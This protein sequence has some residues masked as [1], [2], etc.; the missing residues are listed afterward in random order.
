MRTFDLLVALFALVQLAR[1]GRRAL[2]FVA[3]S[4]RHWGDPRAPVSS[5]PRLR[6][7][8]ALEELGFVPLGTRGE[9][10]TLGAFDEALDAYAHAERGAYADVL[11]GP[12]REGP[13]TFLFTPFADGAAVLTATYPRKARSTARALVGSVPGGVGAALATHEVAVRRLAAVH[14]SPQVAPDLGARIEAA[15]AWYRGEGRS[16]LRRASAIAFVNAA[17]GLALLAG[18]AVNLLARGL[19]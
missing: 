1:Y 3:P 5:A 14:G 19:R 15:R 4:V 17:L 13:R 12:P 18:S 9:R 10:G 2:L 11:D 16:E 7:G 8:E 6:A